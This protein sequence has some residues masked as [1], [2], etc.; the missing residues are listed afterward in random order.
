MKR[1]SFMKKMLMLF[2]AVLVSI[3][4]A[5]AGS[6]L[7]FEEG[8]KSSTPLMVLITAPWA[9]KASDIQTTFEEL[10]E[11]SSNDFNNSVVDLSTESAKEFNKS[12]M[13]NT[14]LP[15]VMLFKDQGKISRHIKRDCIEDSSCF[16]EKVKL[17]LK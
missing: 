7:P 13:I 6:N 9:E 8:I 16:A 15:Y 5:R 17:F 1:G 4:A 12:F 14:N 10:V 2:L 11:S 3:G